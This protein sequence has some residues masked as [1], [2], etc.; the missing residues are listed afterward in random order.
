[1]ERHKLVPIS[2]E[3]K[4]F[5]WWVKNQ[6]KKFNISEMP[7]FIVKVIDENCSK[8]KDSLWWITYEE[9]Y[10]IIHLVA[11]HTHSKN[12]NKY[13]NFLKRNWWLTVNIDFWNKCSFNCSHCSINWNINWN[14]TTINEVKEYFN[15]FS[16]IDNIIKEA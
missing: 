1:M 8:I 14:F 6:P 15:N 3:L 5:M 16:T 13:E 2:N 12:I 11:Y 9:L 4:F 10:D 7:E